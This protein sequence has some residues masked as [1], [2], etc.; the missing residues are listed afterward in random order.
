MSDVLRSSLTFL[1]P[2]RLGIE[3]GSRWMRSVLVVR[4]KI[5]KSATISIQPGES[6]VAT[7]QALVDATCRGSWRKPRVCAAVGPSSSQLRRLVNLP[8]LES[9]SAMRDVVRSSV[10][11]FFL[12]N[13]A[14]L[15]TSSVRRDTDGTAWAAAIDEPPI[16][17]VAEA[18][19][20]RRLRLETAAPTIVALQRAMTGELLAATD[21]D[22]LVEAHVG[23]RGELRDVR[24][25][26][27]ADRNGPN[28]A[29]ELAAALRP[30]GERARDYAAAYGVTLIDR[31]EPLAL[32]ARD[33]R[34]WRDSSVPTWRMLLAAAALVIAVALSLTLPALRASRVAARASAR[35]ATINR[36][37]RAAQWTE[38]E[39]RRTTLALDEL[40]AF[41]R[42]QRSV[43]DF[44]SEI[45]ASLPENAWLQS[46]HVDRRGGTVVAFAPRAA[47]A[48]SG[49]SEIR[50]ITA[51]VIVGAVSNE[52][53]GSDRI[54]RITI[55]FRWRTAER[56][57]QPSSAKS[58]VSRQ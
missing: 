2:P 33:L 13:G 38:A 53:V 58:P 26:A 54:E 7:L 48:L 57:S 1:G 50:S 15:I 14:P 10:A 34:Q 3:V 24:R 11:R 51:P 12:R 52:R 4:G 30:L 46:V 18:C 22:V 32:H 20:S 55:R 31:S 42:D 17:A 27:A 8:A 39:L 49:L 9:R 19:R 37:Y 29:S 35:L 16:R 28:V 56:A 23:S 41:Q 40:A 36:A 5:V 45:T 43:I 6:P 47:S 44:L 21:G 25:I